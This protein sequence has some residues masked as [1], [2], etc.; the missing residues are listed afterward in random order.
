MA[1][2]SHVVNNRVL[3]L[4]LD[5]LYREAMKRHERGELLACAVDLAAALAV[6]PADVPIEGYY[7]EEPELTRYFRLLRALQAVPVERTAEV[8]TLAGFKRLHQV[9]TA[10][11]YGRAEQRECLFPVSLDPLSDALEA[12]IPDWTVPTLTEAAYRIARSTDS[13]SLVGLA[14]RTRDP[15]VMTATRESVVLYAFIARLGFHES[16]TYR[17]E[18]DDEIAAAA[19]RFVEAF[20]DLFSDTLPLP[21][22][23]SAER[24]WKAYEDNRIV[25]RCVRIG[26]DLG[27]PPR[28]YHWAISNRLTLDAF[29]DLEVWT[30]DRYRAKRLGR[31]PF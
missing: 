14:A 20:N 3:V 12:T 27:T 17:W 21:I 25:G 13:I 7:A 28:Y 9:V 31:A 30:T 15:I 5:A 10:P 6:P 24:Y 16:P 19:R 26:Q 1:G 29:W 22:P 4:G 8:A 2:T 18:V 11:I 23:D